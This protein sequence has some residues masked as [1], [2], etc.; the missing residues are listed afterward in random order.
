MARIVRGVRLRV[1]LN[2][3]DNDDTHAISLARADLATTR[4]RE[5]ALEVLLPHETPWS[6]DVGDDVD[7]YRLSGGHRAGRE[8]S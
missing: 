4:R 5:R 2:D 3:D 1:A 7:G 8:K 6:D